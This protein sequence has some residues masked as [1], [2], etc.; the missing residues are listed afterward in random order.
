MHLRNI[1]VGHSYLT[2]LEDPLAWHSCRALLLGTFVGDPWL[3]F[4]ATLLQNTPLGAL[5]WHA[6]LTHLW[7]TFAWHSLLDTFV[8]RSCWA[9]HFCG[10][11]CGTPMLDNIGQHYC[12]TLLPHSCGTFLFAT[13]VGQ[14]DLTLWL[15]TLAYLKHLWDTARRSHHCDWGSANV[16]ITLATQVYSTHF[17]DQSGSIRAREG[18]K[19]PEPPKWNGNPSYGFGKNFYKNIASQRINTHSFKTPLTQFWF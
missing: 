10:T 9:I 8:G 5:T 7:D 1:I 17:R 16:I 12:R 19:A 15:D 11:P 13:L 18:F 6:S 3:C 2:N 4:P 14:P